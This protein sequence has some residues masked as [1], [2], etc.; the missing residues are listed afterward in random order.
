MFLSLL[1][2]MAVGLTQLNRQ[3]DFYDTLEVY[4]IK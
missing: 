3:K 1:F 2:Q 4:Q